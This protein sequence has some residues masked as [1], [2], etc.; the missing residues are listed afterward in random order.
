MRD[1]VVLPTSTL[2]AC[3]TVA[4]AMDDSFSTTASLEVFSVDHSHASSFDSSSNTNECEMVGTGVSVTER[5]HRLCWGDQVSER[6]PAG[7]L[8][9]GLADGTVQL[10]DPNAMMIQ[11]KQRKERRTRRTVHHFFGANHEDLP[12][13]NSVSGCVLTTLQ[14]AHAGAVRGLDFNPFSSNLLASGGRDGELSIWDIN[15]PM[16]P[17][18]YPSAG[19]WTE[20]TAY[21]GNRADSVE[22]ES[23]AHFGELRDDE[24]DDRGLGFEEAKTGDFVC[25]SA[26]KEKM[27]G[28]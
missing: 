2:I 1:D 23:V 22:Y 12:A 10:Y 18:K 3:G 6:L 7:I 5:F 28:D 19:E 4:G 14:N 27:F 15:D 21:R 26:V 13:A 24:R 11:K 8:A 16:K 17:S 9:G 20:W 25:R